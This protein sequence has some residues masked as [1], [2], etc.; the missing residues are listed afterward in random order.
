[1]SSGDKDYENIEDRTKELKVAGR[2][3]LGPSGKVSLRRSE[4]RYKGNEAVSYA[5]IWEKGGYK[6]I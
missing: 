5:N 3:E 4:Q 2:C 6:M 1:M